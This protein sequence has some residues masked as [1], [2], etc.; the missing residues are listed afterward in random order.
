MTAAGAARAEYP[1]V[2]DRTTL[3][4]RVPTGL[5][6]ACHPATP[7][8]AVQGVRAGWHW[9]PRDGTPWL[10]LRYVVQVVQA[11]PHALRLP[12][13]RAPRFADGL[14]RHTCFEA[15]VS[16]PSGSAYHEFNFA[17]SGEWAAYGFSTERRRDAAADAPLA[18]LALA[19]AT[20]Q[21]GDVLALDA[22][23]PM[24]ALPAAASGAP[25]R[26]GLTA[27]IETRDGQLSYWALRHPAARPDFHHH[28]GWTACVFPPP[29]HGT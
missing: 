13:A 24:A 1:A 12:E 15:F 18:R 14:W 20:S 19:P 25:W 22:S 10:H 5:A 26:L 3:S 11:D 21:D 28:G 23:L 17:P 2:S 27:V 4:A 7:C 16:A 8:A 6:L 29:P 9:Y